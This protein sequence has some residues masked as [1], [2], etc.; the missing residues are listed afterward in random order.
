MQWLNPLGTLQSY[1]LSFFEKLLEQMEWVFLG[2]WSGWF[3]EYNQESTILVLNFAKSK[4]M[5]AA[6]SLKCCPEAYSFPVFM[7]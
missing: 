4:P 3:L 6:Q 2:S 7:V 1:V 5:I